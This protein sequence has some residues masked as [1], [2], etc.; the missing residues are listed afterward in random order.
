LLLFDELEHGFPQRPVAQSCALGE[1]L[2]FLL[3]RTE[4]EAEHVCDDLPPDPL[5]LDLA[6]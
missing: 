6:G 3:I 1:A 5:R 2:H 4:G